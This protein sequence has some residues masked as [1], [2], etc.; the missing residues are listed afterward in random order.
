MN[1]VNK[2]IVVVVDC[3]EAI[4]CMWSTNFW[5]ANASQST[6]VHGL[7]PGIIFY[8]LS[9]KLGSECQRSEALVVTLVYKCLFTVA[10]IVTTNIQNEVI[11]VLQSN[12]LNF[13]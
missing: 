8:L 13:C 12:K 9:C 7:N 5:L 11:H 4:Q 3:K 2:K 6:P 10:R 1:S